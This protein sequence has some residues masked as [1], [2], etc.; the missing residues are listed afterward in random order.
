MKAIWLSALQKQEA[1]VQK[2]MSQCKTY[3]LEPRGHFW[4]NDNK[5]ML[6]VGAKDALLDTSV[7]MWII[8]GNREDFDDEQIRYG[9]SMVAMCIQAKRG[10]GFP[11]VI[12]QNGG[13]PLVPDDLPTPFRRAAVLQTAQGGA[14]AK[15]VAMAHAKKTDLP[16]GY[17]IDMVGNV[18][19]G[20]WFEI[21]PTRENWP[22]II[23]GVDEGDI[24]FQA[25]GPAGILPDKTTLEYAMQG[26]KIEK[27]GIEY[28]AWAVKNE[29]SS[30]NAYYVKVEGTPGTLLFGGFS[31]ET[32][33]ELFVI[34]LK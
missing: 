14:P 16:L 28:A 10:N 15:L 24:R 1:D 4:E 8:L 23:F 32:E 26:L 11:I 6:W 34:R 3:G 25:V 7:V 9:L 33:A 2:I 13:D 12:L 22:G 17:H 21:R 27:E 29:I 20:Q 18:H 31:E 5:K 19:F 30:D